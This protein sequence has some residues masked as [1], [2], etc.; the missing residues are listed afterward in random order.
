MYTTPPKDEDGA[1]VFIENV[2][3]GNRAWMASYRLPP[4]NGSAKAVVLTCMDSRIPPL[5]MLGLA[6]GEVFIIRNAGNSIT[7]DTLRSLLI[8]LTVMECRNVLVVGHSSCGMRSSGGL[9]ERVAG[10]VDVKALSDVVEENIA[11]ARSW[12]GFYE[13]HERE[14]ALEQAATLWEIMKKVMPGLSVRVRSA[15]YH[16]EDGRLEMLDQ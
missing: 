1:D 12:L 11:D 15:L 7:H 4:V 13:P 10:A 8:C 9:D 6:P 14:W 2:L 3:N 16:L 5:E